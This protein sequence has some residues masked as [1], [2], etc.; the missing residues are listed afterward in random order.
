[1]SKVK[2]LQYLLLDTIFKKR[3]VEN[4]K[5]IKK[6]ANSLR[7][8]EDSI[9]YTVKWKSDLSK[10]EIKVD[11]ADFFFYSR[12]DISGKARSENYLEK[13]NA[14]AEK[15]VSRLIDSKN[16]IV[17]K[18]SIN[19]RYFIHLF[20]FFITFVLLSF[21]T[22]SQ[23]KYESIFLILLLFF[24]LMKKQFKIFLHICLV[25]A[26][27]FFP[28]I[29]YFYYAIFLFIFTIFEIDSFLKKTKIS[30]LGL[31]IFYYFAL[32]N[33]NLFDKLD[34]HLLA[35]VTLLGISTIINFTKY[36]SNYSWA[37]CFPAFALAHLSIGEILSSYVLIVIC[38]TSFCAINYLDNTFFFKTKTS[39]VL[40]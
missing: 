32:L 9:Y 29:L 7:V 30:L 15:V 19:K 13:N 38:I 35:I 20:Y 36:N 39:R 34:L 33:Y 24:D 23:I 14:S 18:I 22:D 31:L 10:N 1:M 17:K 40:E 3:N 25:S 37:Y 2:S 27:I 5:E 11:K 28:S 21:I 16:T 26:S 12:N 6:I 4:K 8:E